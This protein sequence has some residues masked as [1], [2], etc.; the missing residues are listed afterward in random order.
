MRFG[1]LMDEAACVEVPDTEGCFIDHRRQSPITADIGAAEVFAV[2][3]LLRWC[4]QFKAGR[5]LNRKDFGLIACDGSEEPRAVVAP[6]KRGVQAM[7][8]L[9]AHDLDATCG[10]PEAHMRIGRGAG[11]LL[12]ARTKGD[13]DVR[14]IVAAE[15]VLELA[16]IIPNVDK[17]VLTTRG[18]EVARPVEAVQMQRMLA[19]GE[20]ALIG[21]R[22]KPQCA[23]LRL[24]DGDARTV[25]VK[26]HEGSK[27]HVWQTGDFA[28]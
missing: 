26:L 19:G 10:M 25:V 23:A 11:E 28:L 18:D 17:A 21:E 14:S 27:L 7:L 15:A 3:L 20:N 2:W 24:D 4:E 12:A 6:P 13:A 5:G 8:D 1:L 9:A 22:D 16:V